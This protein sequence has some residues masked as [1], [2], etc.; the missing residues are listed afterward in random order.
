MGARDKW[1]SGSRSPG[2]LWL[3][4][5]DLMLMHGRAGDDC[6][7]T[8]WSPDAIGG[9]IQQEPEGRGPGQGSRGASPGHSAGREERRLA[10]GRGQAADRE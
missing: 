4:L 6:A 1:P 7:P 9:Q 8:L 2:S 3:P 5:G 10:L